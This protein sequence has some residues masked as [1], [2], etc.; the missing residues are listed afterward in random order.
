MYIKFLYV[1]FFEEQKE[2]K[3]QVSGERNFLLIFQRFLA[4]NVGENSAF[5]VANVRRLSN[6]VIIQDGCS[7]Q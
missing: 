3:E 6:M 4:K 1:L 5:F 2:Q 7:L